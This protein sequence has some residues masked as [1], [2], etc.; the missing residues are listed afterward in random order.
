M[1]ERT[2]EPPTGVW[3]CP[4][5]A[6]FIGSTK[7]EGYENLRSHAMWRAEGGEKGA[8]HDPG[9]A[10]FHPDAAPS[11]V[12]QEAVPGGLVDTLRSLARPTCAQCG[13]P[14]EK[15]ACGPT[16]AV[17]RAALG[18]EWDGIEP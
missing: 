14:W 4:C 16:H 2:P 8:T 17:A 1:T 11:E 12:T 10:T 9:L 3:R 13:E 6:G 5:G 18:I 15:W 7:A